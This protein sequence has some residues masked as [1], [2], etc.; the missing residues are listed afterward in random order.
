MAFLRRRAVFDGIR[1]T[2]FNLISILVNQSINV[3]FSKM[4]LK[5]K[6]PKYISYEKTTCESATQPATS[7]AN[8]GKVHFCSRA[9]L[10]CTATVH[11][12]CTGIQGPPLALYSS[13]LGQQGLQANLPSLSKLWKSPADLQPS[14]WSGPSENVNYAGKSFTIS[15]LLSWPFVPVTPLLPLLLSLEPRCICQV[16][17]HRY[18][19]ASVGFLTFQRSLRFAKTL[20]IEKL[21]P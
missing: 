14:C 11:R 5:I 19:S 17:F 8:S 3:M 21:I 7:D 2:L 15:H 13:F 16:Q 4:G 9:V 20:L 18:L 6:N 12:S 10:L 1:L